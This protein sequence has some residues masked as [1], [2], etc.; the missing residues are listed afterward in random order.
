MAIG[1]HHYLVNLMDHRHLGQKLSDSQKA[2]AY[3]YLSN[4]T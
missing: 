3:D 2:A 4:V 1:E